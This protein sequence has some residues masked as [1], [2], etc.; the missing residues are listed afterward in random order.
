[1]S[2]ISMVSNRDS[3]SFSK[4]IPILK[5]ARQPSIKNMSKIAGNYWK[6]K[7]HAKTVIIHFEVK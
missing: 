5:T 6:G 1:M 2:T 4:A 7:K 3:I